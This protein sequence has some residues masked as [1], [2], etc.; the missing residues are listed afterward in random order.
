MLCSPTDAT[1]SEPAH[2]PAYISSTGSLKFFRKERKPAAAGN[3]TNCL[4]CPIEKDCVYSAKKIYLEKRLEQGDTDWPVNIVKPE[5]EECYRTGGLKKAVPMLLKSLG[6][7]YGPD[8]P[9]AEVEARPWYG[10]CV[11]ET[12]ND[13]CD[14][15]FVTISWDDDPRPAGPADSDRLRGRVAK[16]ASFHM[17]AFTENVCHRRGRIYGTKGEITYDSTNI[18]VHDFASGKTEKF[19]P[20]QQ[21]GGHGGGDSGLA[22]QFL[23][24]V[25]AVINHGEDA[26]MAQR[27][28][29]GCTLEDVIRSH[30]MVFAAED[31]RLSRRVLD[32]P[33]WWRE[34]VEEQLHP[35]KGKAADAN[36]MAN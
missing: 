4:S 14:D 26:G 16:S 30:A 9:A 10:R 31:A 6:E 2:L 8:T 19:T 22:R 33:A 25:D 32:W 21:E 1:S 5:I 7:D 28:H 27:K 35:S 3:A 34:N 17:I 24:A 20:E 12:D 23:R 29:L 18:W 15:Q 11:W 13:V 36:G